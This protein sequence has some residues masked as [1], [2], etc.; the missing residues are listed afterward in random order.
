MQRLRYK[1]QVILKLVFYALI[2]ICASTYIE[3][4]PAEVFTQATVKLEY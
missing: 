1:I 2:A 3:V 4:S